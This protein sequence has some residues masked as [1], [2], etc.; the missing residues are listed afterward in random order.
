MT[1]KEKTAE[2]TRRIEIMNNGVVADNFLKIK[3]FRL[4]SGYDGYSQQR[5][6]V[7]AISPN[8][9]NKTICY[10]VK[11]SRSDFKND[12]KKKTSKQ[13]QDALQINFIIAPQRDYLTKMKFRYGQG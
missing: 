11:V 8:K 9:G 6:D 5:C 10:E 3:E 7:F 1:D 12:I 4:G 13:L 2:I